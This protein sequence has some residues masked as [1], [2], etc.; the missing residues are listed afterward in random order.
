MGMSTDSKGT[1]GDKLIRL[2]SVF[3]SGYLTRA[4]ARNRGLGAD[5]KVHGIALMVYSP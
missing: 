3:D 5:P 2:S 4:K 1:G